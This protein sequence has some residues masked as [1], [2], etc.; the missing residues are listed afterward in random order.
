[1]PS[2]SRGKRLLWVVLA[3]AAGVS[4]LVLRRQFWPTAAESL[5]DFYVYEGAEDMLM[6]PLI[7][8]GNDVVPLV[9]E[10]L[11]NPHM[12]RRRYAIGFLGNGSYAEALP[13]LRMILANEGEG[14]LFRGDALRAICRIDAAESARRAP[15]FTA[16]GDYLGTSARAILQEGCA[17]ERRTR[18]QAAAGR[19]D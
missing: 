9:L 10:Q 11:P 13:V 18:A 3:F 2:T 6:D 17:G 4:V 5:R 8:A 19:H 15:A 14:D 7:L 16:R 12:R 1:L